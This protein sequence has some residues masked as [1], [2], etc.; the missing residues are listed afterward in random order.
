MKTKSI[1]LVATL[2]TAFS[3]FSTNSNAADKND[4][5][6]ILQPVTSMSIGALTPENSDKIKPE[7]NNIWIYRVAPELR[8]GDVAVELDKTLNRNVFHCQFD[9]Q[10]SWYGTYLTYRTKDRDMKRGIY[11]LSFK[12]KGSGNNIKC[13]IIGNGGKECV[14]AARKSEKAVP[15]GYNQFR[16]KKEYT[17]IS[18]DYDFS[19]TVRSPYDFPQGDGD[20]KDTSDEVLK[21]FYIIFAPTGNDTEF[22]LDD[23][24]L[25][26][27]QQQ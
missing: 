20:L 10:K 19:K 16:L 6:L 21:N 8:V 5:N 25:A 9:E 13:I 1:T 26:P 14:I 24:V 4:K 23:I 18:L 11:T 2:L 27:K 3:L 7:E 17:E 15:A 22:Y 12:V